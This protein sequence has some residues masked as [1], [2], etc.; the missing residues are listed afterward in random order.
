[1][2]EI[3]ELIT[4]CAGIYICIGFLF[5][6]CEFFE[7][8]RDRKKRVNSVNRIKIIV[9]WLP[10]VFSKRV[11]RWFILNK[12]AV[13]GAALARH[14][15]KNKV[16]RM[17]DERSMRTDISEEFERRV[18]KAIKPII[19]EYLRDGFCIRD[20]SHEA[21]GVLRDIELCHV[22]N[23]QV[24]KSQEKVKS[25]KRRLPNIQFKPIK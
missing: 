21:L 16:K 17:Y 23:V 19:E 10:A 25:Q 13:P 2:N 11:A 15:G 24:E 8:N 14:V 1:M 18:N 4:K 7:R 6:I 20:L 22:M 12:E 5:S 9:G 3:I